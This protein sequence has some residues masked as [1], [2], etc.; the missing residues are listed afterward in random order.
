MGDRR[1]VII[2]AVSP[3]IDGGRFAIKRTVGESVCV[4]ADVFV[5]GHERVASVLLTRHIL[6]VN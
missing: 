1:R 3:E 5:D 6:Q 4:D 2:E